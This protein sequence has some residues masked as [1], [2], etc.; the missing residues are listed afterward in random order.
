M[1]MGIIIAGHKCKIAVKPKP[2]GRP[3][4]TKSGRTYTPADTLR[5]QKAIGQAWDGPC[6]EGNVSVELTFLADEV[7]VRI[8]PM[9]DGATCS[10]ADV[11]NLIKSVLDGLQGHAFLN[12]SQ[13]VHVRGT[14]AYK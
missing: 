12:D 1:N 9:V 2:K 8:Y 14:K 4:F 5:Y 6:F 11:D 3:R 10:R 7:E 13:V